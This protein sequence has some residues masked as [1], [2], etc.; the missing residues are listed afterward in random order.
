M[1]L[2]EE[3]AVRAGEAAQGPADTVGDS[4]YDLFQQVQVCVCV[5]VCVC[6]CVAAWVWV[7]R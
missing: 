3:E 2:E 6:V 5:Y 4:T 7:R 1:S